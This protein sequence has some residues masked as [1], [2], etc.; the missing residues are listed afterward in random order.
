MKRQISVAPKKDYVPSAVHVEASWFPLI[1]KF[2]STTPKCF[3]S[4]R[5]FRLWLQAASPMPLSGFCADCTPAH[6]ESMMLQG[7]CHFPDT[8]WSRDEEFDAGALDL[9]VRGVRRVCDRE[10]V[11]SNVERP[12][13]RPRGRK[14]RVAA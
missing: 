11:V 9:H 8:S 7:R 2:G 13:G 3:E 6:Q 1:P 4:Q 12:R 5:Q 14:A 10:G